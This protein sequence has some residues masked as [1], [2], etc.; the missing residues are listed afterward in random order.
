MKDNLAVACSGLCL[1]HCLLL[2]ILLA[3]GLTGALTSMMASELFHILILVP[4]VGL[5]LF[6]L[7][8]SFFQHGSALPMIYAGLGI[9]GL[10]CSLMVSEAYELWV[11]IPSAL[12][13]IWA[14]LWNRWLLIRQDLQWAV[15]TDG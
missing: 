4:V 15:Q 10:I 8:R 6:S 12:L 9:G 14:H 1:L 13:V 2:P 3:M 11:T 7:P 5:A